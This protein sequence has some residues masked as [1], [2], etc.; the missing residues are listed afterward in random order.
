[1]SIFVHTCCKLHA[2]I[3]ISDTYLAKDP[4]KVTETTA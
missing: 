1:M 2:Y 4:I 3:Y